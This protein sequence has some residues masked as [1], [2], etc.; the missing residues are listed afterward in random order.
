M[1]VSQ[2]SL[3]ERPTTMDGMISTLVW[4]EFAENVNDP[5]RDQPATR[6]PAAGR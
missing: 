6:D 5:E 1:R 3:P 4:P 2:K